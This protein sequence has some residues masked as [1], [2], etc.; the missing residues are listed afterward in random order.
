MPFPA[1]TLSCDHDLDIAALLSMRERERDHALMFCGGPDPRAGK[2][3]P[4]LLASLSCCGPS[5]GLGLCQHWAR[6]GHIA[7]G[8]HVEVGHKTPARSPTKPRPAGLLSRTSSR[9]RGGGGVVFQPPLTQPDLHSSQTSQI[10][11]YGSRWP[12]PLYS[13]FPPFITHHPPPPASHSFCLL[14]SLPSFPPP[15]STVPVGEP[16]MESS[17]Q[18]LQSSGL[19]RSWPKGSMSASHVFERKDRK[20]PRRSAR[21]AASSSLS[22]PFLSR[23]P[24]PPNRLLCPHS[25]R[26]TCPGSEMGHGRRERR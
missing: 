11:A 18:Q 3:V 24:A 6:K 17:Q 2:F 1:E 9:P 10:M 16:Y 22:S 26:S 5:R 15:I 20:T 21:C 13:A 8:P 4:E 12:S 7:P 19:R 23:Q 25:I 14:R